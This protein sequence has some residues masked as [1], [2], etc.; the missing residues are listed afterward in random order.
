MEIDLVFIGPER[1][2][3]KVEVVIREGLRRHPFF[4]FGVPS[5]DYVKVYVDNV[6]VS[7]DPCEGLV[8]PSINHDRFT[9]DRS[10]RLRFA[11]RG[12]T[13]LYFPTTSVN[14]LLHK[15]VSH[16]FAHF[17][18]VRLNQSFQYDDMLKPPSG[19]L[20]R[21][22]LNEL[23]NSYIDGRLGSLAPWDRRQCASGVDCLLIESAW[24]GAFKTYPCLLKAARRSVNHDPFTGG[25]SG[26]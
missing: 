3:D 4:D 21:Y 5:P 7:D 1:V 22:A 24:N 6:S 16:E 18:D 11:Q 26:R 25:R 23:W 2:C 14:P 10:V 12:E 20:L 15:L 17:I 9:E 13:G 8:D 19:S